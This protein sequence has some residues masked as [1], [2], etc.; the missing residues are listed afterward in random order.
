MGS[1][2][3]QRRADEFVENGQVTEAFAMFEKEYEGHADDVEATWRYAR[4]LYQMGEEIDDAK[5]K[6]AHFR[7]GLEMA[8]KAEQQDPKCPYAHKWLGICLS[9]M[10]DFLPTKE[11]IGNAFVIRDHWTKCLELCPDDASTTYA[12]GK[13]CHTVSNIGFVERNAAKLLFAKPPTSNYE[14]AEKYYLKAYDLD[15]QC[16]A[17][18]ALGDLYVD[19]KRPADAKT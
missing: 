6:E 10:A 2:D 19:M 11:K 15:P 5:T 1:E 4:V 3:L 13:W 7:K 12:M 18:L 8:Q 9:K 14:E 16:D 17:P